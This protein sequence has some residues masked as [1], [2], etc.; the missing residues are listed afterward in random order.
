MATNSN[1]TDFLNSDEYLKLV[2]ELEKVLATSYTYPS[3]GTSTGNITAKTYLDAIDLMTN[4]PKTGFGK[5]SFPI[6]GEHHPV[7]EIMFLAKKLNVSVT[8]VT[9]HRTN[10]T[11][12]VLYEYSS[13]NQKSKEDF[14]E[15]IEMLKKETK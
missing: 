8:N 3:T 12:C 5:L 10:T 9:E 11:I 15:A 2:T 4:K 6:D 14:E 7:I 13:E 1:Y